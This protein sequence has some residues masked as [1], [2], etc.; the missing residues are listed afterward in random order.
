MASYSYI[1]T[2]GKARFNRRVRAE[3]QFATL[4]KARED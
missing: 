4:N 2:M 1:K 3:I